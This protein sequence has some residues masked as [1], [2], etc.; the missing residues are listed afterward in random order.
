MRLLDKLTSVVVGPR[1]A[2]EPQNPQVA[3]VMRL[4]GGGIGSVSRCEERLAKALGHA[5]DYYTNVVSAIPGPIPVSADRLANVP[6]LN[7]LFPGT[8]DLVA[9]LA[10]SIDVKENAARLG[11]DSP[12]VE[13][14]YALLGIR[15]RTTQADTAASAATGAAEAFA[16]HT[17]RSLGTDANDTRGQIKEAA[18]QRLLKRF[19][20]RSER[21]RAIGKMLRTEWEADP[22]AEAAV[23]EAK[24]RSHIPRH[25][26]VHAEHELTPERLLDSLVAWLRRPES[27]LRLV[28]HPAEA[29]AGKANVLA[30]DQLPLLVSEDRRRWRVC[31]VQFSAAEVSAAAALSSHAHRYILI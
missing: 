18:M 22:Q 2:E 13:S 7:S 15:L 28:S 31:L 10:K 5:E 3:H 12:G 9:M 30:A 21:L 8:S 23:P 17:I 14:F 16:D 20:A 25:E 1:A 24:P 27:H 4:V 29:A 11:Q 19:A 6:L 26:F